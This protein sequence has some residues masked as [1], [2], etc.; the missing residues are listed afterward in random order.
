MLLKN[1][2]LFLLLSSQF[3]FAQLGSTKSEIFTHQKQFYSDKNVQQ[4]FTVYNFNSLIE[5]LNGE[6]CNEIVSYYIDNVSELCIKVTYKSCAAASNSYM[7]LFN[8]IAEEIETNK[9]KNYSNNSIYSLKI[10]GD[11]TFVEHYY[12]LNLNPVKQYNDDNKSLEITQNRNIGL[13]NVQQ[14]DSIHVLW[15]NLVFEHGG[16]IGGQQYI[17]NNRKLPQEFVF[18]QNNWK[19]FSAIE[20]A[21]LAE[22]LITK[23]SDTTKTQIHTCPYEKVTNGEMAV[24]SL[25]HLYNKNWYDF[26]EFKKYADK[27]GT[28]ATDNEQ[29]WLQEILKNEFDRKKMSELWHNEIDK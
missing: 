15:N 18:E 11:S 20:N 17:G 13:N 21:K 8:Q 4:D 14:T 1:I 25:Q 27:K 16:C 3:A 6:L 29:I 12:D 2:F 22:F 19:K 10:E 9:W 7:K 23:F 5:K 24:Y 26:I 28:N